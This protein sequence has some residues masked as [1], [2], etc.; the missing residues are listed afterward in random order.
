MRDMSAKDR[1]VLKRSRELLV[2]M[3]GMLNASLD[4][5]K[6]AKLQEEA[7]AQ[8]LA[9]QALWQVMTKGMPEEHKRTIVGTVTMLCGEEP[10]QEEEGHD[11]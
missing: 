8:L 10:E 7:T 4:E 3:V 2:Q 6:G 5:R 9:V 11:A 1:R